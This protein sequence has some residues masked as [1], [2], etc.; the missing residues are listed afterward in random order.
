MAPQSHRSYSVLISP[1]Q[2]GSFST[3]AQTRTS[4]TLC[5]SRATTRRPVRLKDNCAKAFLCSCTRG[6]RVVI[7]SCNLAS[8]TRCCCMKHAFG[9]IRCRSTLRETFCRAFFLRNQQ[10]YLTKRF[11][12]QRGPDTQP[13]PGLLWSLTVDL[14]T[15]R[16]R[17]NEVHGTTKA[18]THSR[19]KY[20]FISSYERPKRI[21]HPRRCRHHHHHHNPHHHHHPIIVIIIVITIISIIT[22][23]SLSSSSSP[24]RPSSSLRW[25]RFCSDQPAGVFGELIQW[26]HF[27]LPPCRPSAL[28]DR[29]KFL[30]KNVRR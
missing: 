4:T 18:R 5:R 13:A 17:Q 16:S 23:L 22:S 15:I 7:L 20:R 1:L 12:L 24:L 30:G 3:T 26:C 14:T 19:T 29:E 9:W 8:Q 6:F 11:A 10:F 25:S 27:S 21:V 2:V 28:L